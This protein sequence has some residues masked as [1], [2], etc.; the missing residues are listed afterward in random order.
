M[1]VVTAC[2]VVLCIFE[3][4]YWRFIWFF[5]NPRRVVPEGEN[6]VSPADGTVVY[7]KEIPPDEEI[8]AIKRDV[9]ISIND[10]LREDIARRRI[11][12]GVFMSPFDVHYNRVPLTGRIEFI[13]HHPA[14]SRNVHMGPMHLRVLLKRFPH[15]EN[16]L[17]IVQNERTVT[18]IKG[19]FKGKDFGCY[20]IQIAGRSV[21]GIDTF[22]GEGSLV[23]KGSVFG[24][25]RVGSQVDVVVPWREDLSVKV[26]PGDRVRAGETVLIE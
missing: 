10:I 23:E 19:A 14:M 6:I 15:Y 7:V 3:C 12:I 8:I 5:R 21:S 2:V 9:R 16:G 17:H 1:I 11:L 26:R 20:V 24:I 18:R 25:I 22:V 4:L 13:K